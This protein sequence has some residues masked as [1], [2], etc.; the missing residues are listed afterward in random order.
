V[1][2]IADWDADGAT[3]A[4]M[5]YYAQRYRGLYPLRGSHDVAL[6]PSGPRGF[7][8]TLTRAVEGK[9]CPRALA[10]LDIPLAETVYASLRRFLAQCRSTRLIYI[11]HHY[12]TLH[13]VSKL[14]DLTE[15]VL[16]GHKPTALLTYSL[17]Q[18][19]G[20]RKLTPRLQAFMRAVG[21][22]EKERKP[23]KGE[24][25]LVKLAA[26]ISKATT[27]LR[28]EEL[29]RKLVLWLASPLPAENPFDMKLV[30][31]VL[32]V[33]RRSDA[34]IEEKARMLAFEARRVGYIKFVDARGKWSGR[35]AS[36]LASKLYKI[37]KQPVAVLIERDDGVKLLIVRS[38]GESAYRLAVGLL[39]EGLAENIGGHSSLAV[40]RLGSSVDLNKLIDA[41]RRL[42][43]KA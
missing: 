32:E 19:M 6:Y 40:A 39:R 12:A 9:Q 34:E 38:R 43:L 13:E 41:L 3:S 36:A 20:L 8:D 24:D 14:Y 21:V 37:L 5:L 29:W 26:S 2:V 16:V 10:V 30:E 31:R 27:V 18:S 42:S 15:E 22:L 25:K 35:G 33:A 1:V 7:P 11:D 23:L 4:A 17:L 28:D